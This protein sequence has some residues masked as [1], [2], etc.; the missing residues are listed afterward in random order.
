MV[1]IRKKPKMPPKAP[2]VPKK[3]KFPNLK[4]RAKPIVRPPGRTCVGGP[5]DGRVIQVPNL[6]DDVTMV[7]RV[8]DYVGRYRWTPVKGLVWEN[9]DV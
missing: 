9:V 6:S 2:A 7:M 3:A 5:W 8:G 4:P 1:A